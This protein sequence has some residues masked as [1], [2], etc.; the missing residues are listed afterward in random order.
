MVV[1]FSSG[2]L[3]Y[4]TPFN[5]WG[6]E[7]VKAF[8]RVVENIGTVPDIRFC[9]VIQGQAVFAY[10]RMASVDYLEFDQSEYE[11]MQLALNPPAKDEKSAE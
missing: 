2:E 1:H 4:S 11:A 7:N 6:E 5:E 3:L 9:S 10:V 8:A